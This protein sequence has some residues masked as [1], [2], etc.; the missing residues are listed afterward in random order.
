MVYAILRKIYKILHRDT[1]LTLLNI[2][3]SGADIKYKIR[4]TPTNPPERS[5]GNR[6]GPQQSPH[7]TAAKRGPRPSETPSHPGQEQQGGRGRPE[8]QPAGRPE[9]ASRSFLW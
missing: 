6:R 3:P 4:P 2:Y 1:V 8:T 9:A 7:E 5:D